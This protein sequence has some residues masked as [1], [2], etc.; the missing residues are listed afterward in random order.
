[1]SLLEVEDLYAGYGKLA[2][3]HGANLSVTAGEIVGIVGVNGAGKSSLVKAV[4]RVLTP[5][6]GSVRFDGTDLSGMTPRDVARLGIGYV[7]QG[8]NTFPTLSVE[9]NLRVSLTATRSPVSD[10]LAAAFELFPALGERRAHTAS[11][12]SGGERQ[13]LALA[14]AMATNPKML[15]LDEPTVGL[16]PSIVNDL[17]D[18]ICHARD[19]GTTVLWIVEENPLKVLERCDRSYVM[20]GG[21]VTHELSSQQLVDKQAIHDLFFSVEAGSASSGE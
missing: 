2:A 19:A 17:I 13:M 11:T 9:A 3:V 10:G 14:S 15:V 21:T 5:M 7:P 18:R 12:L 8:R 16:A 1:M 20:Q 4:S 6:R